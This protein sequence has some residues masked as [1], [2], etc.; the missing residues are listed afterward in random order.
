[1]I[2]R[3]DVAQPPLRQLLL[4]A[5]RVIDSVVH[6]KHNLDRLLARESEAGR[7]RVQ[8]MCFACLREY[9]WLEAVRDAALDRQLQDRQVAILLLVALR[10]LQ[11]HPEAAYR[12]VSEAV[13]AAASLKR[14]ARGLTNAVLRN[15][16]RQGWLQDGAPGMTRLSVDPVSRLAY[17]R[18]WV[19][20]LTV[21]FPQQWQGILEAGNRHPP[22]TLRVNTRKISVLQ[23]VQRLCGAGI[24]ASVVGETAIRLVRPVPVG[25]LPG[26]HA[27]EVSVQDVAAQQAARWLDAQDGMR[28]LDACA[29]PGGKTGHI[30]ELAQVELLALDQDAQRL[31]RVD[32]NLQ[33]LG[34]S[35]RCQTGDAA[36]PQEWW[37]GQPFDRILVDAPCSASGVVR[38]HPDIKWLRRPQDIGHFVQLQ[39]RILDALWP[40][41]A[42]GGKLLYATC[43][44]FPDENVQQTARFLARHA[45]AR[46]LPLDNG[47]C[48]VQW[49]P[50]EERDGF[51]YA[52]VT[53][54]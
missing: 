41:L 20:R 25:E 19:D 50:D 48:S 31:R 40:C 42:V 22:M 13:E 14:W 36:R 8:D 12:T 37:D 27:G 46:T 5:T 45:D 26:F 34:L 21:A 3:D 32:E 24:G 17:P 38:R 16:L 6:G 9:G 18:W 2:N 47:Q 15:V 53:K 49:L 39:E 30:L 33:R 23:Y 1:M 11:L 7:A 43:S 29:A 28:V 51:F 35:A 52:L 10:E 44:V 54:T 4:R